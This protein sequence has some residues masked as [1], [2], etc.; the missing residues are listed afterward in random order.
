MKFEKLIN[1]GQ[2]KLRG[3]SPKIMI[4]LNVPPVYFEPESI[5]KE[6]E[7]A[8]MAH[9]TDYLCGLRISPGR[10]AQQRPKFTENLHVSLKPWLKEEQDS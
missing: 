3:E 5:S 8:L 2:N 7:N 1:G 6:L 4:K 10:T 9:T